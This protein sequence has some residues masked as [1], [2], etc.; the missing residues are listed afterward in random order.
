MGQRISERDEVGDQ[1]APIG[2]AAGGPVD[3]R[4]GN[5]RDHVSGFRTQCLLLFPGRRLIRLP[6]SC[7][8]I[9]EIVSELGERRKL[10]TR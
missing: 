2:F 9:V 4:I 3:S 8:D 7:V 5:V 10:A 1:P 6:G